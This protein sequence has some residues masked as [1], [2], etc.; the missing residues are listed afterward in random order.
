MTP[1]HIA[2]GVSYVRNG[3]FQINPEHPPLVKLRVGALSQP[4]ASI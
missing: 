2:A 3:D 1:N 4:R